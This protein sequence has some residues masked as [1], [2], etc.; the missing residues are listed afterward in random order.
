MPDRGSEA[1]WLLTVA[2]LSALFAL[3]VV[4]FL[5]GFLGVAFGPWAL[6][7]PLLLLGLTLGSV[8]GVLL[9]DLD[10]LQRRHHVRLLLF[11]PLVAL[12]GATLLWLGLPEAGRDTFIAAALYAIAFV[13]PYTFL[14]IHEWNLPTG[15]RNW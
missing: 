15:R 6:Y 1:P 3:L 8:M 7:A 4:P 14:V 10:R 9:V 5:Y 13:I 12:A 2:L 11:A